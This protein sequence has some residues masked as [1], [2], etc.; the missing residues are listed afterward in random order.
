MAPLNCFEILG[1]ELVEA[2]EKVA[3]L[4]EKVGWGQFFKHFD[5]HNIEVTKLFSLN[6]K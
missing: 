3:L 5:G 2:D 1:S 4:F 6:L